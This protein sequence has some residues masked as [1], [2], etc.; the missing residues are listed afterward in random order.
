M[1][2]RP[3]RFFNFPWR[4]RHRIE[5]D[6]E[7]E[8]AFHM[9]SR[10]RDLVAG[11][12]SQADAE[13]QALRE[14]GDIEEARDYMAR[15]DR[16]TES[17][18]RRREHM[19]DLWQDIRYA[20]RRMR[21]APVFTAT[22][23]ATLAI[24]I[25]A[26]T[27]VFS[28]VEAA[29]IRPLPYPNAERVV[30]IYDLAKFGPFVTSPTNF[31]DYR[32]QSTSFDG[33]AAMNAY[34]RTV[35]GLGEPQSIPGASVTE[36]FFK[37]LGV[38][39]AVG[40]L[41]TADEQAYGNTRYA[42]LSHTLWQRSF[43]GRSDVVGQTIDVNGNAYRIVGVMPRGFS[44][45]GRTELWTPLAFSAAELATQR[46]AHY[47]DVIALLKQGITREIAERD[48]QA[49]ARQLA[50][51]YPNTNKDYSATTRALRE[52]LIGSTPKRALIVLFAAVGLVALIA[53]ANVANLVLARGTSRAR[54][55]AVR[56]ALG[57]SPRDLLY[58]ALTESVLLALLGGL[59]GLL[60]ARGFAGM[61]DS[62][63]PEGLREVGELHINLTAAA[64]TFALSLV[65]GLLFGIA[66]AV[67]ATRRRAL[68]PALAAGGR[69]EVGERHTNR[70]RSILVAA[71][72]ALA[73]M[74]LCGAG[75]LVKSFAHLQR[76]NTGWNADNLLTFGVSLP[77]AR[78]STSPRVGD[79]MAE[80]VRRTA[81]VPGVQSAGAVS[82][83]PMDGGS[84]SISTRSIDGERLPP[85]DQPSTQI[86]V[87]TP[88]ALPVFQVSLKRGRWFAT[89]DRLGAAPV[90]MVNEA[91][92][93]LLWKGADPL[94]H[95]VE[96]GTRFTDDTTRAHG[97]VVGVVADIRD[98]S[99]GRAPSPAIYF[100]HA[101]APW[102]DMTV[103]ARVADGMD[104]MA[105]VRT[106]R[107]QVNGFDA[108]LP[109]VDPRTMD[110][111]LSVSVAQPRFAA[112]LMTV[113]AALAALLA[114]I[115]VFGVMAYIVGQ[116]SR[117]IGIRMALGASERRV[118]GE[119]VARA[120]TPLV[121]GVVV[122]I[123]GTLALVKLMTNLL[124]EVQGNDPGVLLGVAAGLAVVALL[125]AYIPAR[126]ASTIDPILALRSE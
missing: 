5:A 119:T 84:Y 102:N 42:L 64:F 71:E 43:G 125:A 11:G 12:T 122:G 39:P 46:G 98:L 62:L 63:R 57:A 79:A 72:I 91:A 75:L 115:G 58:M 55:I 54:E 24:G 94:G 23:V 106:I 116:R 52:S 112:L 29:L 118:V 26:N 14:F 18:H 121:V 38:Q 44:Y 21:S 87:V 83:L 110:D 96:I 92:A 80:I 61:L 99:M 28:V 31:V 104:P 30:A 68:Q 20:F 25:G 50:I 56:L 34:S 7:S 108:L 53:C 33:V 47:I 70:F 76:V 124:F 35:T 69:A 81:A 65:A 40:R 6:V 86:R 101:Q 15:I 2:G 111:V 78:Y 59:A 8:L 17:T 36:D 90:V 48:L 103:V 67:Q 114:I 4:S 77:E 22:A 82:I 10:V 120:A 41:F 32:T 13:A 89:S 19:R 16:H 93:K 74:L 45:P 85:Q 117:E 9:E 66:P 109:V 1:T 37:V 113:F 97:T 51:T 126:R 60:L 73:V 88:E 49:I 123:G 105:L 95:S 3:R 107:Q 100:P 27:A